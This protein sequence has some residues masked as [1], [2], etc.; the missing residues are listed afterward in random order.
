M[1]EEMLHQVRVGGASLVYAVRKQALAPLIGGIS[2]S[3]VSHWLPHYGHFA[4]SG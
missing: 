2:A 4:G 1:V 3:S